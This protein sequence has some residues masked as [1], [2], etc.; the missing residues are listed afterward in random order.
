MYV[1]SICV[2]IS[3]FIS[4]YFTFILTIIN[5]LFYLKKNNQNQIVLLTSKSVGVE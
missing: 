4:K 2:H 3:F 1:I 5:I